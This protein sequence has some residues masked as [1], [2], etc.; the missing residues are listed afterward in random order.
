MKIQISNLKVNINDAKLS[1]NEIC[2]RKLNL[3]PEQLKEVI[4]VK[5][6]IDA[7]DKQKILLVYTLIVEVADSLKDHVMNHKEVSLYLPNE[8]K[9]EYPKIKKARRPIIIGFGPSGIFAALYLARCGMKPL[10]FERGSRMDVR[11][12]DVNIFLNN[13]E[14]NPSSNVQFGEGGAGTFSDGKLTTNVKSPLNYFILNEFVKHGAPQEILYEA[15]PHIGTD[16]LSK[17][18]V[19]IREE[20]ENLGGE[21]LF[22]SQFTSYQETE[23]MKLNVY[24]QSND[25]TT[26]YE[27]DCL[28]LALGHSAR[29]TIRMLHKKG[30]NMEA[31]SF[32]MGV[33]IEHK[34]SKINQIQY[35]KYAELLPPASYKL[36]VHLAKRSV[37]TFCMCPGGSVMASAN[38]PKTI[39]TNGMSSRS[40]DL[41]NANSALLV[42]VEPKDYYEKSVL[43]GLKY[44]EKYEKLAFNIA[45]DYRA[46]ANLVYEFLHGR[47]ACEARSVK[48]SYP[49]GVI[50]TDFYRCLPKY[51]VEALKEALPIFNRKI[52][53]FAQDDAVLT[54]VET[55]SS[56]PVRILRDEER[57]SSTKGIYPIGEGA[58]YAG[59]IMSAAFDG[60]KT[61]MQIVEGIKE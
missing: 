52:P 15:M 27:T 28:I 30:L 36:A 39:L 19:S 34:Q 57:M 38:D 37:Y 13:K 59:G 3:K 43:D 55:R 25:E 48:P 29:D 31:K 8:L 26:I 11:I 10:I 1:I 54:G 56:C 49:H 33:R 40:R 45:G 5:K 2:G 7:R 32:S 35:G 24:I 60:L 51:V 17:T 4:L 18:I 58:G 9:L 16:Y 42:N 23:A 6:S 41:E 44:Q 22:N 21:I 20:I 46:P 61:A 14:L 50:M 12:D 53:G 47:V